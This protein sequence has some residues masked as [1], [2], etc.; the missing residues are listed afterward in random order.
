MKN[1]IKDAAVLLVITLFS[2]L[3]LGVVYQIT[4]EPI[5]LAEEK[6]ADLTQEP[7][8]AEAEGYLTQISFSGRLRV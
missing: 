5:A 4:K 1:M 8:V 6:A 3:I 2:G 7:W